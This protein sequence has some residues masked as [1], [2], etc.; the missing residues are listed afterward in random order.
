MAAPDRG[1]YLVDD[2]ATDYGAGGQQ[3]G[4]DR[5]EPAIWLSDPAARAGEVA[6]RNPHRRKEIGTG[7][8][9]ALAQFG[10]AEGGEE[11]G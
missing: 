6:Q 11:I 7:V 4:A 9:V 10:G 5:K 2:E 8:G 1:D 3:V